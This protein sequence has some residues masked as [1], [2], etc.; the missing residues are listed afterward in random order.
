MTAVDPTVA[1]T[2]VGRLTALTERLT[3]RLAAELAAFEAQ[4]PQDVAAGMAETQ[5]LANLYRREAAQARAEPGVIAAATPA[6]RQAL[7]RATEAFD[8]VLSRHA[9]AV[10]AARKIS[11]GL[12]RAIAETVAGE[13][14]QGFGY[15]AGGHA[16]T[17]DGRAVAL[18]R[19]A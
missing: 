19:T 14:A 7:K 2:H 6:R 4:R 15:G 8:A 13:R 11:E 12:V 5:D 16:A 1:D 10:E 17:G 3:E 18:N 9:L